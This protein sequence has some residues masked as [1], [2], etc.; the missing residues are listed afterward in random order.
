MAQGGTGVWVARGG[1][2]WTRSQSRQIPGGPILSCDILSCDYS[3]GQSHLGG[4]VVGSLGVCACGGWEE[5]EYVLGRSL[6]KLSLFG[7]A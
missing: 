6:F 1:Q 2:V 5:W 3:E 7:E 4:S